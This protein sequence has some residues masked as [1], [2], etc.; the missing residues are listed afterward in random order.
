MA[1][2]APLTTNTNRVELDYTCLLEPTRENGLTEESA[3]L[4]FQLRAL[5]EKTFTKKLGWITDKERKEIDETVKKL[6]KI[7]A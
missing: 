5:D 7:D 1:V 2:A 6:L 3:V 4:V